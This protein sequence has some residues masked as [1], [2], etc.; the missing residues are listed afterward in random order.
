MNCSPSLIVSELSGLISAF[1]GRDTR[2]LSIA[3]CKIM[4]IAVMQCL[5]VHCL[6]IIPLTRLYTVH[7]FF[8]FINSI[9]LHLSTITI[10]STNQ[11]QTFLRTSRFFL[12]FLF[13]F[14]VSI[15][16]FYKLQQYDDLMFFFLYCFWFLFS[17][18]DAFARSRVIIQLC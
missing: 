4:C 1:V 17:R 15:I 8:T 3:A 7:G 9:K 18:L 13:F 6:L 16:L 12:F 14:I 11:L 2:T 5:S 10:R